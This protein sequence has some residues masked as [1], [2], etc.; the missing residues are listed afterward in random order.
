MSQGIS[1]TYTPTTSTGTTQCRLLDYNQAPLTA[2]Q[3]S[4]P[5]SYTSPS[6]AGVYSYYVQCRNTTH[7]TANTISNTITVNVFS[8]SAVTDVPVAECQALMSIYDNTGGAN[9]TNKTGWG[10]S[11]NVCSWYGITCSGGHVISIAL[12]ANNLV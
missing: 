2:Y 5:I 7:P 1:F 6:A 10:T 12:D 4:S 11:L 3:A 9:W 8:C